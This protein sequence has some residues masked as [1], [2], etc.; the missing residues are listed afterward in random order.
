M[1]GGNKKAKT[2]ITRFLGSQFRLY[3]MECRSSRYSPRPLTL[4]IDLNK[5]FFFSLHSYV[6]PPH[7]LSLFSLAGFTVKLKPI[8]SP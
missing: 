7:V 2:N 6:V 3:L 1:E 8:Y 4:C 5:V